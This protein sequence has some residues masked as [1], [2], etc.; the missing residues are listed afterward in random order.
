MTQ[1]RRT[2]Y[3]T[4]PMLGTSDLLFYSLK[5]CMGK[6]EYMQAD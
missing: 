2:W 1:H 3:M 6:L 4:G 5:N